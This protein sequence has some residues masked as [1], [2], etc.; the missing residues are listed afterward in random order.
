MKKLNI[1][2][3]G[4]ILLLFSIPNLYSQ[5]NPVEIKRQAFNAYNS[6]DYI[7][8]IKKINEV[9]KVYKQMPYSLLSMRI[10][11]LY[12]LIEQDPINNFQNIVDCDAYIAN[13]IKI[14]R[15]NEL[16]YSYDKV[17]IIKDK[18]N[19]YPKDYTSFTKFKLDFEKERK[20]KRSK[21]S[22]LTL[23]KL[24]LEPISKYT[25]NND[26]FISKL[27][28]SEFEEYYENGKNK[29]EEGKKEALK[30]ER[31]IEK[32]RNL[33]EPYSRFVTYY[34]NLTLG[35]IDNDA[36]EILLKQVK[37]KQRESIKKPKVRFN[38][39][40]SIGFLFGEISKYGLRYESGGKTNR[41]GKSKF[42]G[43]HVSLRS[44]LTKPED[45]LNGTIRANKNEI[46]FGPSFR[47]SKRF[48][49][50]LGIGYGYFNFANLND[51][52]GEL[53]LDREYYF[54]GSAGMSFRLNKVVN[55]IGSF[56]F[57]GIDKDIYRPE[58]VFGC[59]FNL[60]R[61]Y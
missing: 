39:F 49:L 57:I 59:S 6:K 17:I 26:S 45:I 18:L 38:S 21:D 24:K 8:A 35:D 4:I 13:Y 30:K 52:A 61:K 40:N 14:Q 7:T 50:N 10:I 55:V 28:D 46:D 20:I 32:R 51:Y 25:N 29:Y 15:I 27:S 12:N 22:I 58:F 19:L 47:I 53:N 31:L 33:L 2:F 16:D 56:S 3:F 48:Y 42:I 23:R 60:N 1:I 41:F 44:S 9:E 11:S 37:D 34:D 54:E 5:S 36:F 43:F